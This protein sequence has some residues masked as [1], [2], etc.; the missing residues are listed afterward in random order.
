MRK[1]TGVYQIIILFLFTGCF[2]VNPD[3]E[4]LEFVEFP[5]TP[6]VSDFANE[7]FVH[8]YANDVEL[9][10]GIRVERALLLV[11][12][13]A[14]P[15]SPNYISFNVYNHADEAVIFANKG[16]SVQLFC[17]FEEDGVWREITLPYTPANIEITIPGK[18]DQDS[19]SDY[20]WSIPNWDIDNLPYKE[21]RLY[22]EGTGL[23]SHKKY[24]AFLDITLQK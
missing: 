3:A 4:R 8:S 19:H 16:F 15:R 7:L 10:N 17:F 21:I 1:S 13:N 11:P 20:H 9:S 23:Q 18:N 2:F 14:L 6:D 12:N 22:I 5:P 24:G